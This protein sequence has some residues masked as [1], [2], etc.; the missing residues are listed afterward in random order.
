MF[1]SSVPPRDRKETKHMS[2]RKTSDKSIM[3]GSNLKRMRTLKNLSQ[4][5]VA[6]MLQINRSTY[7]KYETNKSNPPLNVIYKL[8][9]IFNCDFNTIFI[10][11]K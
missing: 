1:L 5:Q 9:K 10:N 8:T 6:D 3:L 11:Q 2:R 4:Q 7:A